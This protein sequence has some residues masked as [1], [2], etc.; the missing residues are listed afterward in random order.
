MCLTACNNPGVLKASSRL[1]WEMCMTGRML[2]PNKHDVHNA[3]NSQD[4][5]SFHLVQRHKEQPPGCTRAWRY[6]KGAEAYQPPGSK[7]CDECQVTTKP[8]GSSRA[9]TLASWH[10]VTRCSCM[11]MTTSA[12]GQAQVLPCHWP[13]HHRPT[14]VLN[15]I[16]RPSRS[17]I[18]SWVPASPLMPP[19]NPPKSSASC[20][21]SAH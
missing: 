5:C 19:D 20:P 14:Y 7:Y 21:Q 13:M 12:H 11:A 18:R 2:L 4:L 10:L 9:S 17:H 6:H 15:F 1:F 8:Y 3:V 16:L